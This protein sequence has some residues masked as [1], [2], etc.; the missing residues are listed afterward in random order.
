M[1][2][3]TVVLQLLSTAGSRLL[4]TP[5]CCR[6]CNVT[7][8]GRQRR[9]NPRLISRESPEPSILKSAILG[10]LVR[11]SSRVLIPDVNATISDH[12]TCSTKGIFVAMFSMQHIS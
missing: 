11:M 5:Y 12:V 10:S 2:A 8:P 1:F 6:E 3:M 7:I 4:K 9:R